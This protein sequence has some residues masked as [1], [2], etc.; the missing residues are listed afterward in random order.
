M[1]SNA[2]AIA[3]IGG[4]FIIIA[5]GFGYMG[6][7]GTHNLQQDLFHG[8]ADDPASYVLAF[9]QAYWAFSGTTGLFQIVEEI[10]DPLKPNIIKS[11]LLGMATVTLIYLLANIAYV[12]VLTPQQI[13]SSEAVAM[14]F[15]GQIFSGIFWLMPFVVA[16]STFGTMNNGILAGAR[17]T[18]A[19]SRQGH[20]PEFLGLIN[21]YFEIVSKTI[22]RTIDY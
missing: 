18:I 11:V 5:V 15:G 3:K 9:F 17:T 21:K 12:A 1:T 8:S 7:V 22:S 13:L 19:A 20:L 2:F 4:L 10:K 14:T 6:I 16:C